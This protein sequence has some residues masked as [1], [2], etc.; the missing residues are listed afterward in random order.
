MQFKTGRKNAETQRAQRDAEGMK[1]WIPHHPVNR[2][3]EK[4]SAL[5]RSSQRLC[6]YLPPLDYMDPA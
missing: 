1:F 6:A 2:S 4:T 3:S 5:L